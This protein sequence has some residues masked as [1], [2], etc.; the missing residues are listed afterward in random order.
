MY[1][2]DELRSKSEKELL[3]LISEL[4]GKLLS[5]RFENATGQLNEIHLI[6]STKKDVA[7]VFTALKEKQKNIIYKNSSKLS[8]VQDEKTKKSSFFNKKDKDENIIERVDSSSKKETIKKVKTVEN[9]KTIEDKKTPETIVSDNYMFGKVNYAKLTI[10]QI[11]EELK[12]REI[13]FS[14]KAKKQE[15]LQL[16]DQSTKKGEK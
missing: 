9:K 6:S 13:K 8:S 14:S 7:R 12:L 3:E 10:P 1:K 16:L 2:M 4:K 5:L 11:K 15:L